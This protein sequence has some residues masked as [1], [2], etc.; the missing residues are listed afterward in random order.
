[1]PPNRL[2]RTIAHGA[3]H[4]PGLKRVPVLKLLAAAEVAMLARDHFTR[5]TP[6]E[7]R[8]VVALVRVGRGRRRNLTDAERDE[9]S[10]LIAK[11]EARLLA[12][13]AVDA[14]SPVPLPRRLLY[15]RARR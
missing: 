9:L 4:A 7:R 12:G 1:M 15:G 6:L 2:T 14:F 3:A 5:L 11:V 13:Q 10:A 8:R